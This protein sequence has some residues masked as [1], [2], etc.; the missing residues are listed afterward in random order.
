MSIP[1]CEHPNPQWERENWINLNGEWE[2]DFDFSKS[3]VERELYKKGPLSKKI[4]VPFCPESELS[5]IGYTDFIPAVCYRKV[6]TLN[7]NQL[8]KNIFLHFGAVDYQSFIYINGKKAGE[9]TGGYASFYIDITDFVVVGENEIFVIANDDLRS[10]KQPS[11]K[12]SRT[13]NSHGC[14]Y[15]RT[16]GIWQ[17]VWLEFVEKAYIKDCKYYTDIKNGI[18]T[19]SGV[20]IGSGE[21]KLNAS[22]NGKPMGEASYY[23]E[24][25][26]F[27][28]SLKLNEIH[29]WEIGNG[30]LYDLT[31]TFNC[32]LVKSYFGLRK[33]A[34]SG[35]KFLI[36]D[37]SVF[38]RTVLDQGYYPDGIYTAKDYEA[39]KR[40]IYLSKNLG[41]HGARLHQKIFEK[42]FIYHCDKEGYIIWGEHANWG[43]AYDNAVAQGNFI[44]EWMEILKRDFNSPSIIGWCP[45]NE[46]WRYYEKNNEHKLLENV[47]NI[48]KL[49]DN[50]RPCIDTSGNYHIDKREIYD[51]HDY[52]QDTEKF[53]EHYSKTSEG[54]V[55]DQIERKEKGIQPYFNE[56]I[57]LSEYGGIKWADNMDAG[58]GYG[59]APKSVDEFV[60]R[61][62]KLTDI[63]MSNP[64]IMG[65]CYTQ[66]Y[67]VE[68]EQNGV[69]RY[70]RSC[71]FD[72][73][74]MKKLKEVM[75]K[76]AAIEQ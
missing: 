3:A 19:I 73:E 29:L 9:H 38:L 28:I 44:S 8:T 70:D 54:I 4:I 52:E 16:T 42:R 32:D 40:D 12:Q 63:I 62:V 18:L 31:I 45:F 39:L 37:K 72:D 47:Y 43:M 57:F 11:G 23:V 69:Y 2:F 27:N 65:L 75:I 60:E 1:R 67:D 20:A 56:P 22:Y 46:T 24:D 26:E 6:I 25:G 41:F 36:N 14:Y 58:W 30:R 33:V 68:Q 15:T 50:T 55:N 53:K 21:L 76:K 51:I 5:G 61:Y 7:E 74:T 49:Y 35:K 71:K 17:T 59:N 48:T 34:L 13:Y 10:G 64:D 66:L